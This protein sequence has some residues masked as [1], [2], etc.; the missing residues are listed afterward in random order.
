LHGHL[1]L[2]RVLTVVLP[3]PNG[4]AESEGGT[5]DGDAASYQRPKLAWLQMSKDLRERLVG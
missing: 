5:K 2:G 3:A 1:A 4:H